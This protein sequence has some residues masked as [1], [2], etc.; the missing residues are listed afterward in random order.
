MLI[1]SKLSNKLSK[2]ALFYSVIVPFLVFFGLFATILYPARDLIHPT[3]FC[4]TL[5]SFLPQGL[6]G[7]IAILRNWSYSLFYIMS[8]LWGSVALSLLF[9]GFAN[10]T[11]KVSESKRF[12]SLFGLFANFALIVSGFCIKWASAIRQHLPQ[13]ADP[14]QVS[15][16]YLMGMVTISGLLIIGTYWWINRYVLTD[17]KF[18]SQDERKKQKKEKPKLSLKESFLLLLRSKYLGCIAILVIGY[19][20]AI[21]L[22]E[23]T[24]KGQLALQYPNPNDYSPLWVVSPN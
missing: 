5:Q 13:G 12:Y 9:W 24:W 2:P 21:N 14:W 11:T 18:Y 10:D 23:V 6:K 22:V 7:L 8:E 19:G 16:N 15:L 17:P 20:I 1:Y 3:A 4:D